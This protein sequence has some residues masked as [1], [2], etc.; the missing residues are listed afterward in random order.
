MGE[1]FGDVAGPPALPF[2]KFFCPN[3]QMSLALFSSSPF[4]EPSPLPKNILRAKKERTF[5]RK[6]YSYERAWG[7]EAPF[8]LSLSFL[9]RDIDKGWV[10]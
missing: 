4:I 1:A 6:T 7:K 10:K 5:G 8:H 9:K 2:A 3:Y